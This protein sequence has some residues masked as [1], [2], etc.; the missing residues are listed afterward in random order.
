[1]E[2]STRD[3]YRE[4]LLLSRTILKNEMQRALQAIKPKEKIELVATWKGMYKPEIVDELL[5]VARDREAK[6]RIANWNLEQFD[7]ER[8]KR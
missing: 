2:N 6:V 4:E 3:K 1:M 7:S 5:R 8:I